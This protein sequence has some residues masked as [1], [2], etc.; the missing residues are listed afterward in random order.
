M[1]TLPLALLLMAC[2]AF[3]LVGCSDNS[4]VP[5][6]PTDQSTQVPASLEK[7]DII[8][9][10]NSHFPFFRTTTPNIW[11]TP[12]GQW[13]MKKVEIHELVTCTL[14]PS[15]DPYPLGT[16]VMVHFLSGSYDAITGEGPV[17]G[18]WTM[19]PADNAAQGGCWEGKYEGWRSRTS[20]E[21][22]FELVLKVEA[23]GKGG[24]IDGMQ[25]FMTNTLTIIAQPVTHI[26]LNW[27]GTGIGFVKS[28]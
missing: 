3:V 2:V 14:S 7:R 25:M 8:N 17:H 11:P 18:S 26:P 10:S 6:S 4:A 22:L 24:T 5:V 15:G 23:H 19:E 12:G 16:G 21:N 9:I 20:T 28:H 13:Q 1:K 27:S